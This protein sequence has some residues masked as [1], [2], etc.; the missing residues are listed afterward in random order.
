MSLVTVE[1]VPQWLG[2]LRYQYYEES[3]SFFPYAK[4]DMLY[5]TKD[6]LALL[7]F[8]CLSAA[9]EVLVLMLSYVKRWLAGFTLSRK[10][11]MESQRCAPRCGHISFCDGRNLYVWGGYHTV[12]IVSFYMAWKNSIKQMSVHII[13]YAH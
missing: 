11:M 2:Y 8:V 13:M 10:Q 1:S 3:F 12:S 9:A 6:W 5:L 7:L 4:F